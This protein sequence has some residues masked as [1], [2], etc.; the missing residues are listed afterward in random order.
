MAFINYL[1]EEYLHILSWTVR[2]YVRFKQKERFYKELNAIKKISYYPKFPLADDE[3]WPLVKDK[4]E[5]LFQNFT[6]LDE[7]QFPEKIFDLEKAFTSE[8]FE[9]FFFF[10]N[11]ITDGIKIT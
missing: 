1:I 7:M 6:Y 2:Q 8:F 9:I 10:Y 5:M 4:L 3:N 11:I